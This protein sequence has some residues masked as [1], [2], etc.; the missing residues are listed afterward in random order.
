[1]ELGICNS[2]F[3]LWFGQFYLI[4]T[5]L[6]PGSKKLDSLS[7]GRIPNSPQTSVIRTDEFHSPSQPLHRI[8]E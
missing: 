7:L 3:G 8:P 5:S 4:H 1:M 2:E 6:T